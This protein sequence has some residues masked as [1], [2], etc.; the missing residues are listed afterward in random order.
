MMGL[1]ENQSTEA[2]S[3]MRTLSLSFKLG[4]HDNTVVSSHILLIFHRYYFRYLGMA[5]SGPNTDGSQF[6]I[7]TVPTPWLNGGY[8]V[9]GKVKS[10]IP[11]IL[12]LISILLS[13]NLRLSVE[14][15]WL[16]K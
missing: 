6:F 10:I 5:N 15:T 8:V 12:I 3:M 2:L 9:F 14:W 4:Q 16:R 13:I 1:E 7:T 11:M